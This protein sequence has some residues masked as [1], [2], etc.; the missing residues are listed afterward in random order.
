MSKRSLK[1]MTALEF[2]DCI[3]AWGVT[4][5]QVMANA[6]AL[7]GPEWGPRLQQLDDEARMLAAERRRRS[8]L[9]RRQ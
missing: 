9:R 2:E 7:P 8:G 1:S 3:K 6:M 4:R 5:D